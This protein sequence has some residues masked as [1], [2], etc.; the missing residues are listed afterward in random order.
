MRGFPF[1]ADSLSWDSGDFRPAVGIRLHVQ[2]ALGESLIKDGVFFVI[3][4]LAGGRVCP[5]DLPGFRSRVDVGGISAGSTIIGGVISMIAVGVVSGCRGRH[6]CILLLLS[7]RR[8]IIRGGWIRFRKGRK[9]FGRLSGRLRF[10]GA[11]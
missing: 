4:G 11:G 1:L 7:L 10:G 2:A 5:A 3:A 9:R 6:C 8:G